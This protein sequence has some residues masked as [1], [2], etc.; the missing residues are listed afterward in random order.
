MR[1]KSSI[2]IGTGVRCLYGTVDTGV[3]SDTISLFHN[4]K[5]NSSSDILFI[6]INNVLMINIRGLKLS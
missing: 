2:L 3:R 5:T 6:R 1:D 4:F